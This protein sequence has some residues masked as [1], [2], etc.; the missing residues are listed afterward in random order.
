MK[1]NKEDVKRYWI[2]DK[3]EDDYILNMAQV[4]QEDNHSQDKA[5]EGDND[6]NVRS[7]CWEGKNSNKCQKSIGGNY[8][9]FS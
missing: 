4:E 7:W 5:G 3:A 2:N 1:R 9:E 6:C 8:R